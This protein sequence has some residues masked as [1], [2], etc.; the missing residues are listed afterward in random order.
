MEVFYVSFS[1]EFTWTY[2]VIQTH[3]TKHLRTASYR[4]KTLP[5]KDNYEIQWKLKQE[6]ERLVG[7]TEIQDA[8]W[9]H[10]HFMVKVN[11]KS[12]HAQFT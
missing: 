11:L 8:H 7:Q 9:Y 10:F 1:V 4:M 3:Q 6:R 5:Q 12:H 2:T